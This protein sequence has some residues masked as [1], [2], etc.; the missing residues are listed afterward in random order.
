[1]KDADVRNI[2]IEF[3]ELWSDLETPQIN[4]VLADNIDL[5]LL[6]FFSDYAERFA[7]CVPADPSARELRGQLPNL[8]IV[9]Y[10]IR[11]L[12]ERLRQP[13]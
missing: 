1:M 13:S 11:L 8:L 12:E 7:D 2:A 9:G 5:D 10:L 3:A 4:Q 6:R